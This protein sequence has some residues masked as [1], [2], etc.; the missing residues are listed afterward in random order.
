MANEIAGEIQKKKKNS[1]RNGRRTTTLASPHRTS[2]KRS[3][4]YRDRYELFRLHSS[5]RSNPTG[6]YEQARSNVNQT[7][8]RREEGNRTKGTRTCLRS[9]ASLSLASI[10]S[11]LAGAPPPRAPSTSLLLIRRGGALAAAGPSSAG[12]SM[13]T[14]S[15]APVIKPSDQ[16]N[17]RAERPSRA[18]FRKQPRVPSP[19]L[20]FLRC[21]C[22]ALLYSPSST[23]FPLPRK[24]FVPL[25]D[26]RAPLDSY[27]ERA[28]V[29][30]GS[31]ILKVIG[32]PSSVEDGRG[33]FGNLSVVTALV[34]SRR[35]GS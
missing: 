17:S 16:P 27:R 14:G 2:K 10:S 31:G 19:P 3:S 9:S 24:Y 20:P 4:N 25:M 30:S 15:R 34:P 13:A 11:T 35:F 28:A 12:I 18:G 5:R 1:F 22:G 21:G 23:S 6:N 26:D 33:C 32:R 29:G 8:T 7:S